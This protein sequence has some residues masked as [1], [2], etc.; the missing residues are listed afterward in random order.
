MVRSE[1][2]CEN[3]VFDSQEKKKIMIKTHIMQVSDE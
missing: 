2:H 3:K 1:S